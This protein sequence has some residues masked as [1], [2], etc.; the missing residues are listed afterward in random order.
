MG[1]AYEDHDMDPAQEGL[2]LVHEDQM[3]ALVLL[4]MASLLFH[5]G[6]DPEHLAL[7]FIRSSIIFDSERPL[8]LYAGP[9]P[10]S[11]P[12]ARNRGSH[13]CGYVHSM[14][15]WRVRFDKI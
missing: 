7:P 6:L 3:L 15:E 1:L 14:M 13:F 5:K 8:F 11:E 9:L 10:A 2:G 4:P 12:V